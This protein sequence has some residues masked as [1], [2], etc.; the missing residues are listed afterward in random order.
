MSS[1]QPNGLSFQSAISPQQTLR[2]LSLEIVRSLDRCQKPKL[3]DPAW[4]EDFE[5][6]ITLL[7][8]QI[9]EFVEHF[10][11]QV[12]PRATERLKK[13]EAGFEAYRLSLAS[14]A[15]SVAEELKVKYQ[16]LCHEYEAILT[17]LRKTGFR[18]WVGSGHLKPVNYWRNLFHAT[19][20]TI[21]FI[22]YQWF[23]TR[24]QALWILGAVAV[25]AVLLEVLRKFSTR[26]NDFLVDRVFTLIARPKERH[27]VNSATWY[28]ISLVLTCALFPK[29]AVLLAVLIL[30][31]SDPIA[32]LV[33]KRWGSIK[34]RGQKSLQGTIAFA[35]SALLMSCGYAWVS[36]LE[37]GGVA[38]LIWC[39]G[40]P[41]SATLAELYGD[42]LDDNFGIL[43]AAGGAGAL[44]LSLV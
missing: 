40:V 24:E 6:R 1:A 13:L 33:G 27:T 3:W 34:V 31:Y 17:E 7:Q 30:G 19:N 23:L 14:S 8:R 35:L 12:G 5:A 11:A 9:R 42:R 10:S 4:S 41:V 18:S 16:G 32:S 28:T 37:L 20:A 36:G 38:A 44:A 15:P 21:A 26:L 2:Q 29:P 43:L 39:L 22:L 25:P